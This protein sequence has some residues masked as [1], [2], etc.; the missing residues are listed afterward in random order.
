M[1]PPNDDSGTAMTRSSPRAKRMP[2]DWQPP[3]PAWSADIATRSGH[4]VMAYLA[5]QLRNG[6]EAE[7]RRRMNQ[8]LAARDG[9]DR[10]EHARFVDRR[11]VANAVSV[12]Y[13]TS[14]AGYAAWRSGSGY[15]T[16][17]RDPRRLQA[18]NGYFEEVLTL[19]VERIETLF[20]SGDRPVG[21]GAAAAT[22]KGPVREHN[23]WGSMRDRLAI[24]PRDELAGPYGDSLPR[25]GRATTEGKRLRVVAPENLAVIR[26]GQDWAGCGE[27]ELQTY[28]TDV[29]PALVDGMR[30]L[31][32][33]PDETG[34]CD[35][36]LAFEVAP[37]GTP[38]SQAFGLGYFLTLG[39]LERWAASHPTHL[40]IFRRFIDMAQRHE[41]KLG[42]RLWHEVSVLPG[43]GQSFEYVNCHAETGLLPHFPSEQVEATIR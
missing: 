39:H 26:S 9:P 43:A 18:A 25:L 21:I 41:G 15:E 12:A 17:W 36:R 20:S 13:W 37:D 5:T 32:E 42:L 28:D 2:P 3:V 6:G 7:H 22:L 11:G 33:H 8:F 4:L 40:A 38:L 19:P 10:V 34:C 35:M 1:T 14:Q 23:Y 24:S 29:R 31:S 16:W 27:A 30:Y